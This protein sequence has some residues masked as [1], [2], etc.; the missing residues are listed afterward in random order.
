MAIDA[1]HKKL[2]FDKRLIEWNI[3]NGHLKSD[4]LKKH[5]ETLEDNTHMAV[6]VDLEEPMPSGANTH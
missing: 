4:E 2:I 5:L 3:K 1:A 6:P